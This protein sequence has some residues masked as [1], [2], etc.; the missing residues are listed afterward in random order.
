M[1][2]APIPPA[3][4][5]LQNERTALAW[6]RTALSIVGLGAL[7]AKQTDSIPR[8]IT[9]LAMTAVM[10]GAVLVRADRRQVQRRH[11][12]VAGGHILAFRQIVATTIAAGVLSLVGLALVLC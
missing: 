12:Q 6:N 4:R 5:G 1:T 11:A 7:L 3:D 2:A 9:I 10:A 8:A